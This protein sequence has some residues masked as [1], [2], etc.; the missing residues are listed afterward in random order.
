MEISVWAAFV[1]LTFAYCLIPGPSVCFTVAHSMQHGISRTNLAIIG[2]ITANALYIVLVC[3]GLGSLIEISIEIFY[4][5]K[6]IGAAYIVYLGIKQI[7]SQG[8]EFKFDINHKQKSKLK[9]YFDGFVI[10]GTNP[11]TFFY[12]AAFLT[13]FIIPQYEK[14]IQ[15]IILGLG[16]IVIASISLTL[17]NVAGKRAK[18]LLLKKNIFQYS[19]F[20]IGSLF[21]LAGISLGFF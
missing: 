10:N 16:S 13:Q 7:F 19:H 14:R 9:S 15:L 21:I 2:Q 6:Y 5:V 3:F 17:Y 4:V 18:D 8:F 11:K 1:G 12:Y 20:V